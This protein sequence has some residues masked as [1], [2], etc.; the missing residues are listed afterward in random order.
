MLH[1]EYV[2]YDGERTLQQPDETDRACPY[3]TDLARVIGDEDYD[4]NN[5]EEGK[6]EILFE[7]PHDVEQSLVYPLAIT[8]S[9][10]P[11]TLD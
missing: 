7:R 8:L 2:G 9:L 3:R 11:S 10:V 6:D 1:L 4:R 5:D